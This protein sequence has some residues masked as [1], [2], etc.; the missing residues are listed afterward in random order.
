MKIDPEAI[1]QISHELWGLT[2]Q[3]RELVVTVRRSDKL[4]LTSKQ[5]KLLKD[6]FLRIKDELEAK[7]KEL[8]KK[9]G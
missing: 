6:E 3:L 1:E 5:K 4:S 8:P 2:T 7:V 9:V